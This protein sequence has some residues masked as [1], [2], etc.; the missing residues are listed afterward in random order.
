M[1]PAE[2]VKL[3]AKTVGGLKRCWQTI[4]EIHMNVNSQEMK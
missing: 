3:A 1:T 2:A 4:K